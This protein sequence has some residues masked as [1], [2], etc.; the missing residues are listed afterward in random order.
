MNNKD[1]IYPVDVFVYNHIKFFTEKGDGCCFQSNDKIASEIGRHKTNISRS[2]SKLIRLGYVK[3]ENENG[4]KLKTIADLGVKNCDNLANYSD[5]IAMLVDILAMPCDNIAMDKVINSLRSCDNLAKHNIDYKIRYL[6]DN[7]IKDN[8][9][10]FEGKVIKLTHKDYENWQKAYP[11]L[12]L[13]AE[14]LVRDEW[15]SKQ[16]DTKNWFISTAKYFV[17]QNEER[18]K[19]HEEKENDWV[20]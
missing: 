13:Y 8:K 2:I 3:S 16:P 4:R 17:N 14:C 1:R 20:F 5:K 9:Y 12:N 15:L 11:D 19:Q 6:N 18:K 7:Y 10:A